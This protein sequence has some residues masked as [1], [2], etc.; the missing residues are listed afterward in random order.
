MDTRNFI[1]YLN[2]DIV[3]HQE[4]QCPAPLQTVRVSFNLDNLQRSEMKQ[5]T[6]PELKSDLRADHV[7][8][9]TLRFMQGGSKLFDSAR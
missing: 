4:T 9:K 1:K 8:S 5:C 3:S 6:S 2:R 7:N